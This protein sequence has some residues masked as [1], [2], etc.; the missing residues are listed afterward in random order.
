[1]PPETP[2]LKALLVEDAEDDAA[3]ALRALS[4]S[5]DVH[6]RRSERAEELREALRA[7]SWDVVLSDWNLPT[8]DA[9][10]VSQIGREAVPDVP[11]II[12]YGSVDEEAAVGAPKAGAAD[13]VSKSRFARLVPAIQ[14]ELRDAARRRGD[15]IVRERLEVAERLASLGVVAASIVH[16]IK[17][18]SP[19]RS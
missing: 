2:V 13:F 7:E 19:S 16:E 12:V 18:P 6:A 14:R 5:Y 8:L 15:G 1:M 9:P 4:R 3:L 11:I 17:I 10:Q